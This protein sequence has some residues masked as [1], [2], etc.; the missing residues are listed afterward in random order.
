MKNFFNHG[1][2]CKRQKGILKALG[3]WKLKISFNLSEGFTKGSTLVSIKNW[4]FELE[5]RE[6]SEFLS[7][8]QIFTAITH[9][10]CS[11]HGRKYGTM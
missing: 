6:L 9:D 3:R 1:E 5:F 7:L 8:K 4:N 11:S 2:V 10:F